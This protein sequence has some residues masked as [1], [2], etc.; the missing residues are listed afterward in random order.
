MVSLPTA[1]AGRAGELATMASIRTSAAIAPKNLK[2]LTFISIPP[3]RHGSRRGASAAIGALPPLLLRLTRI[4]ML[5]VRS[6]EENVA[7][8]HT[9]DVTVCC[10]VVLQ[11]AIDI[12]SLSAP[13]SELSVTS[14]STDCV[15]GPPPVH[16]L[17][18]CVQSPMSCA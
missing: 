18:A 8:K 2:T 10:A 1:A 15:P 6:V 13:E 5:P 4:W 16:S 9:G 3:L 11:Y 17:C 14:T 7:G 12:V